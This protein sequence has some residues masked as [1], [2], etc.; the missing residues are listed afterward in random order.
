[1]RPASLSYFQG[2]RVDNQ[3]FEDFSRKGTPPC[4]LIVIPG[5]I[6]SMCQFDRTHSRQTQIRILVICADPAQRIVSGLAASFHLDDETGIEDQSQ[7]I[8]PTPIDRQAYD[9]G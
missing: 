2:Q 1:M 5:S 6:H 3:Y 7:Q 8:N 4:A 9:C